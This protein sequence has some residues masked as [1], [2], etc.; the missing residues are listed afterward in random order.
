MLLFSCGSQIGTLS[1]RK[2][3]K[4]ANNQLKFIAETGADGTMI[5]VP[6]NDY[7]PR[8]LKEFIKGNKYK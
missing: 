3:T 5:I 2:K 7:D 8:S 6:D 4:F 1:D